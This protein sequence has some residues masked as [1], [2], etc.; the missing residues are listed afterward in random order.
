MEST[1]KE[2]EKGKGILNLHG[3]ISTTTARRHQERSAKQRKETEPQQS[4]RRTTN[5]KTA[6]RVDRAKQ[7]PDANDVLRVRER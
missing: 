4:R 3:G 1:T 7:I 5:T 6:T 2:K